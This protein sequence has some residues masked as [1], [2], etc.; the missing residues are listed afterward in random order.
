[1]VAR[2]FKGGRWYFCVVLGLGMWCLEGCGAVVISLLRLVDLPRSLLSPILG[3][4]W[5]VSGSKFQFGCFLC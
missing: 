2:G 1:M 4:G 3:M 5:W